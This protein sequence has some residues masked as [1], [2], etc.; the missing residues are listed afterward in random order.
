M[1][2][3]LELEE[4]EHHAAEH[5][6]HHEDAGGHASS[7]GGSSVEMAQRKRPSSRTGSIGRKKKSQ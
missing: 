1:P 6:K 2:T 3:V 5:A 7:S 4:A